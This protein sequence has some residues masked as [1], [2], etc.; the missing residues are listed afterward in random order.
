MKKSI[1]TLLLAGLLLLGGCGSAAGNA[2]AGGGDSQEPDVPQLKMKD[3]SWSVDSGILD[4]ER[5]TLM[6]LTNN[7]PYTISELEMTFA[8]KSD[9]TQEEKE[10]FYTDL[11]D[12][13][14]LDEED[15]EELRS[16]P[17]SMTAACSDMI[18]PGQ[19]ESAIPLDYFRGYI[20]VQN[21]EHYSLVQPDIATISYVAEGRIY[22]MYYDFLSEKATYDPDSEP[23]SQWVDTELSQKI[24]RPSFEIIRCSHSDDS[25]HAEIPGVNMEDY[26]AYVQQCKDLGFTQDINSYDDRYEASDDSGF[27]LSVAFHSFNNSL[28]ISLDAPKDT[29]E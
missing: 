20:Y 12:T 6:T 9:V 11:Q 22:T 13:Y 14:D 4:G 10:S 21:F 15:L 8:V 2:P 18:R 7:S 29:A 3:L 27:R 23:A 19:S 28:N 17:L 25:I 1:V 16:M 5:A 26:E 24:P